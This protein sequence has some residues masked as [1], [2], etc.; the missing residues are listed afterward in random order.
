M[1]VI[2]SPCCGAW[3][4]TGRSKL[5]T[6]VAAANVTRPRPKFGLKAK[7]KCNR[8]GLVFCIKPEVSA[9]LSK[10]RLGKNNLCLLTGP[11]PR[12]IW[13]R[14][15]VHLYRYVD[16][17]QLLR[18]Y[19]DCCCCCCCRRGFGSAISCQRLRV[20]VRFHAFTKRSRLKLSDGRYPANIL[21]LLLLSPE[22]WNQKNVLAS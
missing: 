15:T 10:S 20:Y 1:V 17:I 18:R 8:V 9:S 16:D 5:V 21:L 4:R 6:I 22:R 14:F 11:I 7:G 12:Y 3:C 2:R 13:H 19:R